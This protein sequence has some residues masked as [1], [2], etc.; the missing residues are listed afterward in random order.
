MVIKMKNIFFAFFLMIQAYCGYTQS[1]YTYDL[2]KDIVLGT[3][4]IGIGL[5]P[6]TAKDLPDQTPNLLDKQDINGFD[7]SLMFP[8]N[9]AIDIISD[10]GVYGLLALP[11]ISVIGNMH[12]KNVL[13]TYGIMYS[14]VGRAGRG[15]AAAALFFEQIKN[16]RQ[17]AFP[18]HS[19]VPRS[20]CVC[21]WGGGGAVCGSA[22]TARVISCPAVC[23][24]A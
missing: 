23:A 10:Y 21:A 9:K 14:A 19:F 20:L 5:S 12:D 15:G 17:D 2:K 16:T 13:L 8:Y 7:R 18:L 1:V 22:G 6:F 3:L 24:A 4:S 11:T